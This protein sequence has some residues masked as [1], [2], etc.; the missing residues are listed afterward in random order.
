[1][2]GISLVID[3]KSGAVAEEGAGGDDVGGETIGGRETELATL[4]TV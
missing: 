1:M 2:E 3:D 4:L